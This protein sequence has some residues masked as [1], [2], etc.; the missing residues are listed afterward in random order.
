MLA[1]VFIQFKAMPGSPPRRRE[2]RTMKQFLLSFVTIL[3]GA[4]LSF[5]AGINLQLQRAWAQSP[6]LAACVSF[7]VGALALLFVVLLTR[8]HFPP[9]PK[10]FTPWHW[11]G[12]F[13]GAFLVLMTV[14]A[15]PRL[16]ATAMIAL[17]LAGQ[18]GVSLVLDH[19]GLIGYA[20]KALTWR[21][22]AGALCLA[23]GVLLIQFF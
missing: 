15:A 16:G 19:F 2:G 23:A 22:A 8:T 6:L 17:V 4:T 9:L 20:R 5:Q 14:I 11:I 21:R 3:A 7:L 1:P 10:K 12:G 13:F 18:I